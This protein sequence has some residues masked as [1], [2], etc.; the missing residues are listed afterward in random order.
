MSTRLTKKVDRGNTARY[1]RGMDTRERLRRASRQITD[2]AD[3][4]QRAR[5]ERDALL[6]SLYLTGLTYQDLADIAGLTKP[7]VW[8]IISEHPD[9]SSG[10][11]YEERA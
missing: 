6:L 10:H 2:L 9:V 4:L 11:I 3:Q 7:R 8:K 1:N 5:A